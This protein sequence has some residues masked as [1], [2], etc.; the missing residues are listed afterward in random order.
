[1]D[2]D[3]DGLSASQ[4]LEYERLGSPDKAYYGKDPAVMRRLQEE[5]RVAEAGRQGRRRKPAERHDPDAADDAARA[6]AQQRK[7]QR[8]DAEWQR[9]REEEAATEREREA[10]EAELDAMREAARERQAMEAARR[11][12]I[13]AHGYS[14]DTRRLS[15]V[16]YAKSLLVVKQ[17]IPLQIY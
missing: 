15:K 12:A 1:M 9:L 7:R 11:A 10:H 14:T 13:A 8:L 6:V 2:S 3:D 17:T 5:R 16:K 4:A